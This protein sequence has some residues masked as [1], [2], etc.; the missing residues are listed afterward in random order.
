MIFHSATQNQKKSLLNGVM[1]KDKITKN[2]GI[3][4]TAIQDTNVLWL[5]LKDANNT[6]Q[7]QKTTLSLSDK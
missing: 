5:A 2:S 1:L 6:I 4:A 7:L 3:L